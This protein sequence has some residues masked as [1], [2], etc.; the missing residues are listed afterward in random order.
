M[1]FHKQDAKVRKLHLTR[2]CAR[3][4]RESTRRAQRT[5]KLGASRFADSGQGLL[6]GGLLFSTLNISWLM[7]TCPLFSRTA[8]TDGRKVVAQVLRSFPKFKSSVVLRNP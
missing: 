1:L 7:Q 6:L 2:R 3:N 8:L 4:G 5:Q